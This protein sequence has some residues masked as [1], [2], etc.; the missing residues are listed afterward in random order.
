MS[1]FTS[2]RNR[3]GPFSFTGDC[4]RNGQKFYM[5]GCV[6]HIVHVSRSTFPIYITQ[7]ISTGQ[8]N[9]ILTFL[10]ITDPPVE[11]PLRN[12][13]VSLLRKAISILGKTGRSQ[14]ISITDGEGVRFLARA[15]WWLLRSPA[16]VSNFDESHS[17]AVID[18]KLMGE[19]Y[20]TH[21][22]SYSFLL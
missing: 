11:S 8:L 14:I 15:R 7:A 3:H 10:D 19:S 13:P 6:Q 9:T 20:E 1:Q 17:A 5:I 2:R 12:I 22:E 21:K 4:L 16:L 18:T